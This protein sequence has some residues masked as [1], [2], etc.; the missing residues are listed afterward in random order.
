MLIVWSPAHV[1]G[2][3]CDEE[4][5]GCG[6][7]GEVEEFPGRVESGRRNSSGYGLGDLGQLQDPRIP[8]LNGLGLTAGCVCHHP[9]WRAVEKGIIKDLVT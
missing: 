8:L 9:T 6:L 1:A 3:Q 7:L 4:A 5:P 2:G